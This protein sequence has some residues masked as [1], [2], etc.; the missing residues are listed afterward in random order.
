MQRLARFDGI[1]LAHGAGIGVDAVHL[2]HI[3]AGLTALRI[4]YL[5][6]LT[7][8]QRH[9]VDGDRHRGLLLR[10]VGIQRDG[11]AGHVRGGDRPDLRQQRIGEVIRA[12]VLARARHRQGV[13]A[14][15]LAV[16]GERDGIIRGL[17][18]R[19][20]GGVLHRHRRVLVLAV[21][22][23]LGGLHR[24]V[25][26]LQRLARLDGIRLAHR[27]LVAV[28]AVHLYHVAAGFHAHRVGDL[29][30]LTLRQHLAG[31]VLH[32]HGGLLLRA[33]GIE[34]DGRARHVGGVQRLHGLDGIRL[35]HRAAVVA[36]AL[37]DDEVGTGFNTGGGI[38]EPVIHALPQRMGIFVADKYV[39][40]MLFPAVIRKDNR[41]AVNLRGNQRSRG[42]RK[43]HLHRADVFARAFDQDGV[44]A[45]VRAVGH[46]INIIVISPV[47]LFPRLVCHIF[48]GGLEAAVI[49]KAV[50][51][52]RN[53][54]SVQRLSVMPCGVGQRIVVKP[55]GNRVRLLGRT[56]DPDVRQ[57]RAM[58]E[59]VIADGGNICREHKGFQRRAVA[60]GAERNCR[61]AVRYL[62]APETGTGIKRIDAD[63]RY[64]VGKHDFPDGRAPVEGVF[65]HVGERIR[66]ID[67]PQLVA[68]VE[69]ICAN[70]GY[71]GENLHERDFAPVIIP[72]LL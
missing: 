14:R 24:D 49:D 15:G 37:D 34:S 57:I 25:R 3:A 4:R 46:V 28:D 27:A 9:A 68:P 22:V 43:R 69:R 41:I 48:K 71:V 64:V 58:I 16:G 5:V 59:C 61:H 19:L 26:F 66:E 65:A 21:D 11:R 51:A 32:R 60:K 38:T 17:R 63:M 13:R 56:T 31:S 29:I 30:V 44:S 39:G 7:L 47:Q 42:D 67:R 18:Q 53:T 54:G 72:R 70:R 8:R 33:V 35:A 36:D 40:G 50:R 12:R 52:E 62:D 45:G 55:D 6:V 20:S 23:H 2:K 10:A 1:R